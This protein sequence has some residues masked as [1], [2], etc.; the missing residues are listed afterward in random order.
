M[1]LSLL[2][3]PTEDPNVGQSTRQTW[4]LRN[5]ETIDKTHKAADEGQFQKLLNRVY[6]IYI[7]GKHH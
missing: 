3:D 4:L 7:D 2:D 6:S 5:T 1:S